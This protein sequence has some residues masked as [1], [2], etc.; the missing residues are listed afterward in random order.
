MVEHVWKN[1]TNVI[2]TGSLHQLLF[3]VRGTPSGQAGDYFSEAEK[4]FGPLQNGVRPS[5]DEGPIGYAEIEGG[6]HW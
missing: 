6:A 5:E 1:G 3:G 2:H 4:L